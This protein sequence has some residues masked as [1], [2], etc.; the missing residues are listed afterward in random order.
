MS[1]SG[2]KTEKKLEVSLVEA[3]EE[4]LLNW[5]GVHAAFWTFPIFFSA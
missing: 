3:T 2:E 1:R 5:E 4:R